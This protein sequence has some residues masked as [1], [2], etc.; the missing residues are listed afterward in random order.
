MTASPAARS[1]G[2]D[3][4]G[5]SPDRG[6]ATS[7]QGQSSIQALRCV[8]GRTVITRISGPH[9]QKIKFGLT[10]GGPNLQRDRLHLSGPLQLL[11]PS[12]WCQLVRV[13]VCVLVAV[14]ACDWFRSV[15]RAKRFRLRRPTFAT[16]A[17]TA[18]TLSSSR[19]DT[20]WARLTNSGM[21]SFWAHQM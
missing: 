7:H 18:Y 9:C 3:G 1:T 2:W 10:R 12:W 5:S 4:Y 21:S 19:R 20:V 15:A 11:R 8:A 16:P 17:S 14:W 13:R 6:S